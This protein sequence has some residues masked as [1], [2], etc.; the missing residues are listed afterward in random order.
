MPF[1]S[2]VMKSSLVVGRISCR[3]V[4]VYLSP[5]SLVLR[6]FLDGAGGSGKSRV[7]GELLKYAHDYTSRLHVPFNMRTIVVTAMSGVAA[8]SM[9]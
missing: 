1:A 7:V 5:P 3:L 6:M 2:V 8:T 9:W 4:N